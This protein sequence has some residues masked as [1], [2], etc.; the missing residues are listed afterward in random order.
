MPTALTNLTLKQARKGTR[1]GGGWRKTKY[2]SFLIKKV[3]H[4]TVPIN[5]VFNLPGNS[6][7]I[8]TKRLAARE[9]TRL[10]H[11]PPLWAVSTVAPHLVELHWLRHSTRV[12][13]LTPWVLLLCK[14]CR[15]FGTDQVG[16]NR[17]EPHHQN[18]FRLSCCKDSANPAVGQPT[19]KNC[20]VLCKLVKVEVKQNKQCSNYSCSN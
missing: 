14:I 16:N 20:T 6:T 2:R 9:V 8:F 10:Q 18:S 11:G 7:H 12:G 15:I 3:T 13:G 17:P 4:N 19:L 5:P 1:I